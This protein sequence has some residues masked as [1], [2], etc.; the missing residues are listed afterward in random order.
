[1][2]FGEHF[3]AAFVYKSGKCRGFFVKIDLDF[4]SG[5]VGFLVNGAQRAGQSG[6]SLGAPSPARE[7]SRFATRSVGGFGVCV[8]MEPTMTKVTLP[9]QSLFVVCA[10]LGLLSVGCDRRSGNVRPSDP[11]I[12]GSWTLV[13][14][15]YPL[16][17]EYRADG[18][19]VQHVSGRT[20]KPLPFRIEGKYLIV[21][22]KQPD[23]TVS[24]T[25]DRIELSDDR[26]TFFDPGGTKRVFLR[27]PD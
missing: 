4:F 22:V 15:D 5:A 17:N 14:G 19:L 11:R 16:T 6:S 2:R 1:M 20:G 21:S 8:E 26:L 24:D 18:T 9:I 12:I 23:G 3:C 13:G 7:Y 27:Q 25:K 10:L